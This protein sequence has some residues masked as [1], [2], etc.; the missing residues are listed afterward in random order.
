MIYGTV[1]DDGVPT[2]ILS[3]AGQDWLATIDTGF[4]G[5]LE[6]PEPLRDSLN[7]RYVGQVTSA[8]AGGQT[9]EEAVY[10]VDFPF[11]GKVF[12]AE[13]TFVVE[14][15][16]LIGTHLLQEYRLQV[17]FVLQIVELERVLPHS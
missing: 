6:L 9:I 5:D 8:L 15:Q 7:A 1:S 3:I 17:N 2:I 11:D 12:H 10:L 13:A 14:H 16:I 4:N